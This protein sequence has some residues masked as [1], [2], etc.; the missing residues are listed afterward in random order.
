MKDIDPI[1]KIALVQA[2]PILFDK[3]ASLAKA[4]EYIEES[5]SQKPDLI[6][7]PELFIPGYPI[8]M[9]FGFS[10]GKRTEAGRCD[11]KRYYDTSVV[12]G[13]VEFQALA[14]AAKKQAL[15]SALAFRSVMRST[16][17]FITAMSF[18]SQMARIRCIASSSQQAP[19]EWSGAMPTRAISLSHK[20]RGDPSAV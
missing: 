4:L 7:F 10:M 13:D 15:I 2:E 9:D 14:D 11:W 18:L 12:A 3:K 17:R 1:C 6:V 8:G 19:N 20:R 5:A 16:E